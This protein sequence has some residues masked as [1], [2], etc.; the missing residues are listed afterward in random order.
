MVSI[1]DSDD[2]LF[3]LGLLV[4]AKAALLA[5]LAVFCLSGASCGASLQ[6]AK[7]CLRHLGQ[8][9]GYAGVGAQVVRLR[10]GDGE[11]VKE[12]EGKAVEITEYSIGALGLKPAGGW[13]AACHYASL[14]LHENKAEIT[15]DNIAKL[16][17]A[18]DLEIPN[19]WPRTYERLMKGYDL[20]T[21]LTGSSGGG[22]VAGGSGIVHSLVFFCDT[23][24]TKSVCSHHP[25][26]RQPRPSSVLWLFPHLCPMILCRC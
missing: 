4:M 20:Q 10:G 25:I 9:H 1:I 26:C 13:E 23:C 6:P 24:G 22:A 16:L 21:L 12:A 2:L 7:G 11:E 8:R 15:A 14:I 3:H 19:F 17:K 5:V 18:A